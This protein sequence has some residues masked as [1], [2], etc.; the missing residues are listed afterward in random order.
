MFSSNL[1]N[2]VNLPNK[3]TTG[4]CAMTTEIREKGSSVSKKS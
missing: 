1:T 4:K 2:P 3:Y